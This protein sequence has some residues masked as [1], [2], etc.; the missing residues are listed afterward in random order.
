M[1]FSAVISALDRSERG[2]SMMARGSGKAIFLSTDR[3]Y[4]TIQIGLW[5]ETRSLV[6]GRALGG[7]PVSGRNETGRT[8]LVTPGI[9]DPNAPR[10]RS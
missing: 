5:A 2:T 10:T 9:D 8:V 6:S 1:G 7:T 3:Q 4:T